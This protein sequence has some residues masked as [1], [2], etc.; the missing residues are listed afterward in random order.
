MPERLEYE[1][2]HAEGALMTR[3]NL[4]TLTGRWRN[5]NPDLAKILRR[6]CEPIHRRLMDVYVDHHRP[7]WHVAWNVELLWRNETP[8]SFPDMSRDIFAARG[9]ILGEE[10]DRLGRYVDIRWCRG[11]EFYVQKLAILGGNWR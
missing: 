10:A 4:R 5:L 2:A 8:F 9:L 11:D 7:A 3:Q 6:H 1:L